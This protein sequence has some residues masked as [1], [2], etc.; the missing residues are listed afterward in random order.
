MRKQ[1]KFPMRILQASNTKA[2]QRNV[3]AFRCK[4]HMV[5]IS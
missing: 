5:R 3:R 1:G 4:G 2:N